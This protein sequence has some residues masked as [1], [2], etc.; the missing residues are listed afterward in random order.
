M[1]AL[2]SGYCNGCYCCSQEQQQVER[3]SVALKPSFAPAES[4]VAATAEPALID[5]YSALALIVDSNIHIVHMRMVKR[6]RSCC[7]TH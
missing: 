1:G 7:Y 2:Q 3:E 5:M 4:L 6:L